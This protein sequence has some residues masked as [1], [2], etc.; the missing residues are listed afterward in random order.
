[1][2]ALRGVVAT[3]V[4]GTLSGFSSATFAQTAGDARSGPQAVAVTELASVNGAAIGGVV[5]DDRGLPLAGAMVSALGAT[6]G[7]AVT[8]TRGVFR[9]RALPLGTYFVRAHLGGY[10]PSRGHIVQITSA[11]GATATIELHRTG[12]RSVGTAGEGTPEI[13]AAGFGPTGATSTEGKPGEHDHSETAWRLRHLPRSVMKDATHGVALAGADAP[14][15]GG[16]F[17]PEAMARLGRAV[18]SSAHLASSL[19]GAFP[20]SGQL[21]LM[22][23]GAFDRPQE[24]FGPDG[25]SR[26]NVAYFSI[27]AAAGAHGDWTVRGALTQG[28]L[29]SWILA[30]TY[31]NRQPSRHA[32][33]LG[34]TY[35]TQRYEGANPAALR[36]VPDGS[37]N[38]GSL[39]A[40]DRWTINPA[41]S[42]AYGARYSRYDYLGGV[43]LFSPHLQVT[44]SPLEHVR[45]SASASQR[46]LAPGAEEFLPPAQTDMF[47][48]PE[49]TF[50]TLL[51]SMPFRPERTQ[52]V[53]LL[54][55][56]DLG[57]TA[58]IGIRAFH[59]RV[60]DQL[61]AVFGIRGLDSADS[62][63][64]H[65]YV[66]NTGGLDAT[67]WGVTVTHVVSP[68][69]RGSVAYT[70]T[71]TEWRP[72]AQSA[73]IERWAPSAVRRDAEL[74]HDVMTSLETELPVTA[75]RLVVLYRFNN[76]F[77]QPAANSDQPGHDARF[78]VQVNQSLPFLN[79]S[80]AQWEMLVGVRNMFREALPE[81]SVYD[82]L[83]VVQ[84]P[85]RIVGGLLVRF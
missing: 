79:F 28:D 21:N 73:A 61:L 40:S 51:P 19:L 76:A 33:Q 62:D 78:D 1:M 7:F 45:V 48:P 14:P 82:E 11:S 25:L 41:V 36:T 77:V 49:R 24:L 83:L 47:L 52:H 42:V 23:R 54:V 5:R 84:P 22:T 58:V 39:L 44:V 55:E 67:G 56:R 10:A 46:M 71:T 80:S 63:V 43:E 38:A 18:G 57:S 66:A 12:P 13:V 60:D 17:V 37:R 29:A 16:A 31:H 50:A 30:G 81:G 6:I 15:G 2:T 59:Q 20:F 74:L 72:S 8:D 68:R 26:S 70:Q 75:T 64:G 53:E 9:I 34:M 65:Y 27:G 4:V 35:A 69:L 3:L 85:K 32:Y